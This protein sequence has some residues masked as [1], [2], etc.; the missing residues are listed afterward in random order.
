M[1]LDNVYK[2]V[3]GLVKF[4]SRKFG[5]V[6]HFALDPEELEAEGRLVFAKVWMEH[7]ETPYDDV[8]ARFKTSLYN[9]YKSML[10]KY[11][12]SNK[13]GFTAATKEDEE[14]QHVSDTYIDLSDVADLIGYQ[15]FTEIYFQEYVEAMTKM[16]QDTPDTLKLFEVCI[17]SPVQLEDMAVAESKRKAYIAKQGHLVRNAEIVR[18]RQKHIAQYLG[19]SCAKVGDH[20]QV[21]QNMARELIYGP[22]QNAMKSSV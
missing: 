5:A 7:Q 9:H 19:W 3:E 4:M 11:R 15:A 14:D 1:A 8:V 22:Y 18:I 6:G 21:L 12:Y 17:A 10:D 13:R 20:L 2:Q 16:L